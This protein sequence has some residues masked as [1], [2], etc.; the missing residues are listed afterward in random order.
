MKFPTICLLSHKIHCFKYPIAS[1]PQGGHHPQCFRR[2]GAQQVLRCAAGGQGRGLRGQGRCLGCL[3]AV[4]GMLFWKPIQQGLGTLPFWEYW[5]S[6]E[7]VAI[8]KT[9]YR[10][11]LGDVQWGH[12]MIHVQSHGKQNIICHQ[13]GHKCHNIGYPLVI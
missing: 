3:G 12:L 10:F 1:L 8:K 11:W 7:K 4:A 2:R 13:C 9:I 6:P 5:T